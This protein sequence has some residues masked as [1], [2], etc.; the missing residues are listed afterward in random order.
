MIEYLGRYTHKIAISNHRL[1]SMGNDKVSFRYKDY[2]DKG[3]SKTMTL[4]VNE[5]LRRFCLHILPKGFR[6]IRHY[7]IFASR[8]KPALKQRQSKMDCLSERN[9]EK[10]YAS[11]SKEQLGF[12]VVVCP[13]CKKGKMEI[14]LSFKPHALPV[15]INNRSNP[16]RIT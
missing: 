8:N 14:V 10:D 7:G 11:I 1:Q 13:C 6:K 9:A 12:D 4:A 3:K 15:K 2:R 5:F 16:K